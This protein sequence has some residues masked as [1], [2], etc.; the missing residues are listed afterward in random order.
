MNG[1]GILWILLAFSCNGDPKEDSSGGTGIE[2]TSEALDTADPGPA[3]ASVGYAAILVIDGARTD[4][5]IFDGTSSATGGD[6]EEIIPDFREMFFPE[7]ALLR[8]GFATG[9]TQTSE[10]HAEMVTG[11]RVPQC[12]M[13]SDDGAGYYR[14]ELPTL[15]EMV[16]KEYGATEDQVDLVANT[17]HLQGHTWGVSPLGGESLG[18]PYTYITD[19][20]SREGGDPD[21]PGEDDTVVMEYVLS[22]F[23]EHETR[24]LLANLHQI[25]R[26]GH[27]SPGDVYAGTITASQDPIMAFWEWIQ[28]TE[29]YA[30]NTLLVV[31]ADHGRHRWEDTQQD[32]KDHGDQCAGCRQIP[33]FF[34]GPGIRRDEV[35]TTA[36]YTIED[37]A[38]TVAWMLGLEMPFGT[39]MIVR[40]ALS[41][42][43]DTTGREGEVW[44]ARD[45]DLTAWQAWTD[46][47]YNQSQIV[48]DGEI[49]SDVDAIHAEAPRVLDTG[50]HQFVCWR[51][52]ILG[53]GDY[54]Y[55]DWDWLGQCRHRDPDG[56]WEDMAF[57]VEPVWPFWE[58]SLAVDDGGRF[59]ITFVDNPNASGDT[60]SGTEVR[61]LR[62]TEGRGWEG[63]NYGNDHVAYPIYPTM[64][65]LDG[66][67]FL[68]FTTSTYT[69]DDAEKKYV[70]YTRHIEVNKVEWGESTPSWSVPLALEVNDMGTGDDPDNPFARM[71][72]PAITAVDGVLHLAF[73][74]YGDEPG[75]TIG[76][77]TSTDGGQ[78]WTEPATWDDS[79]RVFGYVGPRWTE[80]GTLYWT[81]YDE[82][83][84]AEVC[85]RSPEDTE[86]T[87]TDPGGD[88]VQGLAP[89][90]EGVSVSVYQG[91]QR[92]E[93]LEL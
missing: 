38:R 83:E 80:D 9:V 53:E 39:G 32:W 7:G 73:V 87:C 45:G 76:Y 42:P 26:A 27:N 74:G 91:D 71:T 15:Y 5:T 16:R 12:N 52:L 28:T 30:D 22:Q 84:S 59:W 13:P 40:E 89:T 85:H 70:R 36:T 48:V 75:S 69:T 64:T 65:F 21:Q 2:D 62:W 23:E 60:D 31:T 93:T 51:E 61:V 33:V 82:D 68:A 81:R 63:E 18:S 77:V 41:N 8:P 72:H 11:V 66:N 56:E 78:T 79:G 46:D 86:P 44:V 43:P 57:P 90:S 25:D 47:P 6:T 35:I 88:H 49:L 34:I 4:E 10:G 54:V 29:P 67:V 20:M 37:M 92:W 24:F 3:W 1:I 55:E 14:P 19:E 50:D 58:P 17:P